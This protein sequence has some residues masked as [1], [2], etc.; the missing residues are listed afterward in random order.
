MRHLCPR[1]GC[2]GSKYV[3]GA[4]KSLPLVDCRVLVLIESTHPLR[5]PEVASAGADEAASDGAMEGTWMT[6]EPRLTYRCTECDWSSQ[7]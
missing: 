5:L 3:P 7:V 2:G 6:A 1:R 4:T